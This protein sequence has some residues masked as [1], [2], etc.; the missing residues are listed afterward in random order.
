MGFEPGSSGAFSPDSSHLAVVWRTLGQ[1]HD[2]VGVLDR[3]GAGAVL[4][5]PA[6][7]QPARSLAWSPGGDR[8]FFGRGAPLV[9]VWTWHPGDT[10]AQQL[11]IRPERDAD[12]LVVL[13]APAG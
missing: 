7:V 8:L 9:E 4:I 3:A 10:G 13:P 1:G 2:A 6:E 5:S 11:R 12:G